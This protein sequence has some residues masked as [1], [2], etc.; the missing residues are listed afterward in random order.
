MKLG[1]SLI[2]AFGE[3][4]NN[5]NST[6]HCEDTGVPWSELQISQVRDPY[7]PYGDKT[8]FKEPEWNSQDP[9]EPVY[10]NVSVKDFNIALTSLHN[11]LDKLD[12][13]DKGASSTPSTSSTSSTVQINGS[14]TGGLERV[15][16][17]PFSN[18]LGQRNLFLDL[19]CEYF[20]SPI[21]ENILLFVMIILFVSNLI[22]ICS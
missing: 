21:V 15:R 12:G 8:L 5:K 13:T 7:A 20:N 4:W 10:Q 1:C 22:D 14:S 11:R 18:S 19:V 3:N 16:S 9:F 2:E 6:Q 17:E